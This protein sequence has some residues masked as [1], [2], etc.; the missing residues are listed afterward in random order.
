MI[1]KS[2]VKALSEGQ[3][4]PFIGAGVSMTI[5]T[6]GGDRLFPSW[7]DL[8]WQAADELEAEMKPVEANQV[9]DCLNKDDYLGAAEIASSGLGIAVWQNFIKALFDRKI[10]DADIG[11]F[12]LTKLMWGL[13]SRLLITTNYDRTLQWACPEKSDFRSWDI[14]ATK[15]QVDLIRRGETDRPTVWH[16]HGH[17]DNSMS[18]I[19]TPDGYEDLYDKDDYKSAIDTFATIL[20]TKTVLFIGFSL[21]DIQVVNQIINA[22]KVYDGV[23]SNHYVLLKEDTIEEYK[24]RKIP[25]QAIGY[26][27]YDKLPD[28]IAEMCKISREANAVFVPDSRYFVDASAGIHLFGGRSESYFK[29]YDEAISLTRDNIDIYSLKLNRFLDKWGDRLMVM[30]Q[31]M[32]IRVALLDPHFPLPDDGLSIASLREQ[33]EQI[34]PGDI[35]RGIHKWHLFQQE[36]MT[37]ISS[38]SLKIEADKGL[39]IKLYN[40]LPTLNIFKVDDVCFVG[41]YLLDVEDDNTPTFMLQK[42][43]LSGSFGSELYRVYEKHFNAVWSDKKSRRLADVE[44]KEKA[45]WGRP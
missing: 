27:D 38:G 5:K 23:S 9:R 12:S 15:E 43:A 34:L 33:E 18:L 28:I 19:L 4:V 39:E 41:P 14:Q 35:K 44:L 11:S 16:L 32:R 7:T 20:K 8:L 13:G 10:D 37:K 21:E 30:S 31:K 26:E 25:V 36:Y 40:S 3:V 42:T 1:P 24:K 22:A 29:L 17:I 45:A 6:P 2:L